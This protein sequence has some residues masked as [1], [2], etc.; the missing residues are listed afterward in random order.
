MILSPLQAWA[1]SYA[2]DTTPSNNFKRILETTSGLGV[3][4]SPVAPG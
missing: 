1:A 3:K 2:G 4:A